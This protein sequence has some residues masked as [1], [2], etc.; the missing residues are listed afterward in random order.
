MPGPN[1]VDM[2]GVFWEGSKKRAPR[3]RVSKN[4]LRNW[5][6]RVSVSYNKISSNGVTVYIP[7]SSLLFFHANAALIS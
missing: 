5:D 7:G 6:L 4:K 3:L 1:E 2:W